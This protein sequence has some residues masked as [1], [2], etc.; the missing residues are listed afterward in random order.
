MVRVVGLLSDPGHQRSA[1]L[2]VDVANDHVGPVPRPFC[3]A[4]RSETRCTPC[5]DY[6]FALDI[7][8]VDWLGKVD[9]ARVDDAVAKWLL[10]RWSCRHWQDCF[11]CGKPRLE[12]RRALFSGEHLLSGQISPSLASLEYVNGRG[13]YES[14]GETLRLSGIQ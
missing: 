3:K 12:Q 2:L 7:A 14:D 9:T 13:Q 1:S 5:D 11:R 8:V 4:C 10:A 6:G